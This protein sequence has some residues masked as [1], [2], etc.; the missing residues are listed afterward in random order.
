MRATSPDGLL[1]LGSRMVM[2]RTRRPVNDRQ[3]GRWCWMR[4]HSW[5]RNWDGDGRE[6]ITCQRC[7]LDRQVRHRRQR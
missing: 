5:D 7:S 3:M 6:F 4:L 2:V 1:P